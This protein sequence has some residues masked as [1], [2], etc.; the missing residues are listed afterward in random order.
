MSKKIKSV[1]AV[2]L[3]SMSVLLSACGGDV[4]SSVNEVRDAVNSKPTCALEA[5][6]SGPCH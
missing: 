5:L 2:I 3:I 1:F 4:V 6:G